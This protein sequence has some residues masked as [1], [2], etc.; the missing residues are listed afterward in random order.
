MSHDARRQAN[1]RIVRRLGLVALL[2]FGFGFA[3]VP[4]YNVFCDITG[5]NG[6]TGRIDR[7]QALSTEVDEDRLVT[8]EFLATVRSDLHWGFK[9]VVRRVRVH[10]GEVTEVHYLA[11]NETDAPVTGQAV[12][13]VA[14]GQAARYFNKTECFCF[15]QQTL[16]AGETR[17]MPIRFVVDPE[18]PEN[19]GTIS[20]SYTFFRAKD[21]KPVE[22][23]STQKDGL[24]SI[25]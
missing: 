2:M 23:V 22:T 14:P 18:L 1:R 16:A 7:E 8:V 3:L 11:S 9:P 17:E 5:I 20:L 21:S 4:L 13:S 15:T 6:K 24:D 10:P 19:V 25:L 12:P